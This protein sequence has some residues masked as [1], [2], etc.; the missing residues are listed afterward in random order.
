L[1]ALENF[2]PA[3]KRYRII[4]ALPTYLPRIRQA[5]VPRDE[6]LMRMQSF[7]GMV[8]SDALRR[9]LYGEELAE[10]CQTTHYR[11]RTYAEIVARSWRDDPYNTAQAL[12][13]NTWLTGNALLSQD[14]TA[15]AHSL[16]ARVPFFD[17]VLLKFA[18]EV[19]P[20]LRMRGNKYVLREAM[21]PDLPDFAL[22]RP[23]QPFSTPILNWFEGDLSERIQAVLRDSSALSRRLFNRA[24]L[25]NLLDAHFSRRERHTEVIFRLLILELWQ[26]K[27]LSVASP[28]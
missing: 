3:M 6:G 7:D 19:P 23:K 4:G 14:K 10:V 5:V 2:Y 25:D 11:E 26:Q 8:F 20:E 17:P 13:I 24:G 18:A 28:A 27:F 21:R 1:A 16:E 15:M 22:E 9:R 12:V